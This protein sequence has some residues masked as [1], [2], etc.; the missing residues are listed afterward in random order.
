MNP[1][2]VVLAAGF[3]E[4]VEDPGRLFQAAL[5]ASFIRR[6]EPVASHV[7]RVSA[8]DLLTAFP[9]PPTRW[10]RLLGRVAGFVRSGSGTPTGRKRWARL[11]GRVAGLGPYSALTGRVIRP[12]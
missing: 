12:A 4:G 2:L 3:F 6:V 10:A 8:P 1:A 5:R 9:T 11:L 7:D